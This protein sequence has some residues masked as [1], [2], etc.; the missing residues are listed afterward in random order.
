M[1]K[2]VFVYVLFYFFNFFLHVIGLGAGVDAMAEEI[3]KI[4]SDFSALPAG[5]WVEGGNVFTLKFETPQEQKDYLL[6]HKGRI[7]ACA[8]KILQQPDDNGAWHASSRNV[9]A[10]LN[11]LVSLVQ[12]KSD[13]MQVIG[14]E[15]NSVHIYFCICICVYT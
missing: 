8:E 4:L 11:E 10:Y 7:V 12:A 1:L 15:I 13:C 3:V 14:N 2:Y 6:S 5:E 9:I